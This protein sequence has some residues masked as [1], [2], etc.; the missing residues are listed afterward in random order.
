MPPTTSVGGTSCP[1][2]AEPG[3]YIWESNDLNSKS[4]F[5]GGDWMTS[6][7]KQSWERFKF[8]GQPGSQ[9]AAKWSQFRGSPDFARNL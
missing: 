5:A 7:V 3:G 6:L 1:I 9:Q 8:G 2:A 4:I